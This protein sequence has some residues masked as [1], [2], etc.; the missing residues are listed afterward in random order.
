MKGHV[1]KVRNS[2]QYI[3]LGSPDVLTGKRPQI[4]KSGFRTEKEAWAACHVAMADHERGLHVR[5]NSRTVRELIEEWLT[6]RQHSIKPSMH[7]NYRNYAQYYV[8]PYIGD[9]KAQDLESVV[10]DALYTR[11][12]ESGRVK[13]NEAHKQKRAAASAARERAAAARKSG[14]RRGPAPKPKVT[15]PE[16]PPGLAPKTVVN[17]HRM[18]H[19]VWEDATKWQYVRRNFVADANPPRVPRR[20]PATWSIAQLSVFL[21]AAKEDRFFPLW[22]LEATTGMRRSELAGASRLGLDV[23]AATLTLHSTRVVIDGK[24]IEEDGKS[25]GS[26]RTIALDP[27]TLGLLEAHVRMLDAERVV[28]GEDYQDHGLLFCWEDGRPP[29][30]DTITARFKRISAAAGLPPIRLHDVRHS[31]AT[32]GRVAKVDAKALSQRVGHS[33]LSFT[34]T[35]YMHG[36]AAA[37]REVADALASVILAGLTAT[38]G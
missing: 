19:R 28:F 17:V 33:S 34:M 2:Y 37:D 30:P 10:F 31:Y 13:A 3:F 35:T 26:R 38:D 24:V 8:L 4:T 7:A 9:R 23:A 21:L 1:R 16:P 6:R 25:E 15:P 36:D 14:L 11:L 32:A 12:L 18:L 5:T 29:H 20:S 22:V 27:Y